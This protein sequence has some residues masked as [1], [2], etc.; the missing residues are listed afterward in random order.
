[1]I[2]TFQQSYYIY[3]LLTIDNDCQ[4]PVNKH[5]SVSFTLPPLTTP[6]GSKVK[7]LNFASQI[8]KFRNN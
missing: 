6:K 2:S 7:Y 4:V 3:Q 1:M 8:F 5:G